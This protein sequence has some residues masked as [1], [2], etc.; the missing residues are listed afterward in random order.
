MSKLA[1]ALLLVAFAVSFPRM[2][3]ATNYH[4]Y[5]KFDLSGPTEKVPVQMPLQS[6]R[7]IGIITTATTIGNFYT[8]TNESA[9]IVEHVQCD[10]LAT[11]KVNWPAFE[12]T[13]GTPAEREQ[14]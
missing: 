2:S 13:T 12:E 6:E 14:T 9:C 3:G 1:L 11:H 8:I 5:K 10:E 4:E 7:A